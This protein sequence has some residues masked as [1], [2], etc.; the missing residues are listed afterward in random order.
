MNTVEIQLLAEQPL[1]LNPDQAD[2]LIDSREDYDTPLKKCFGVELKT[3]SKIANA[4]IPL[5]PVIRQLQ[6][7]KLIHAFVQS[8]DGRGTVIAKETI[9]N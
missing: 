4:L 1:G 5:T 3:F 7:H 2:V 6:T 9:H 8:Q